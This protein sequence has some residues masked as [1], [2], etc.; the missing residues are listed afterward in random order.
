MSWRIVSVSNEARLSLSAESLVV[1]QEEA[2]SIPLE[3]INT[4][5]LESRHIALT[6]ALLD[7]CIR[8]KIAVVVCDEKHAPSGMVLGYQQH[9]RQQKI[10]Q[11]QIAWTE[12]FKKRLW[13]KIIQQKIENQQK[14]LER[15][16]NALHPKLGVYAN[17]VSSGDSNNREGV[18]AKYYFG[19]L[20]CV[21]NT[22]SGD[23]AIN[24]LLNYGYALVRASIARSIVTYG[25]LSS[26][27]IAHKSELNNFNL[28]D[29]LI[30]PF[31]PFVDRYVFSDMQ[32]QEKKEVTREDKQKCL[33][34]LTCP[35]WI[36]E[37]KSTLLHAT[38]K[39]VQ[40][41]VSAT[42]KRDP[43]ILLLPTFCI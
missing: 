30:E 1:H 18:A 19:E 42:N 7:A 11:A 33:Q 32:A 6:S 22:R 39:V 25:F 5:M 21:G 10:I 37:E 12:P 2:C 4:L 27:G 3:D 28:A 36:D 24:A 38:D 8:H 9:S 17:A 13:Q 20:F 23:T 35:V 26:F 31:R 14:M 40:S 16:T 41:L 43:K 34:V 15:H 29:D